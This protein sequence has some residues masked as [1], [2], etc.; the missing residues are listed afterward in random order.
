MPQWSCLTKP[1]CIGQRG[2]A[3]GIMCT[4]EMG[5]VECVVESDPTSAWCHSTVLG[6]RNNQC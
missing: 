6:I 2:S 1:E 5:A 4:E 3:G